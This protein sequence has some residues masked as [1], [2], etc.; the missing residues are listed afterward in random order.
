MIVMN[1]KIR[2]ILNF[3]TIKQTHFPRLSKT[4]EDG[5]RRNIKLSKSL[6]QKSNLKQTHP[7][8][9]AATDLL[10]A[11]KNKQLRADFEIQLQ[12]QR[13][14]NHNSWVKTMSFFSGPCGLK[15]SDK[16]NRLKNFKFQYYGY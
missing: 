3:T 12:L 14:K 15:L 9:A 11:D 13:T 7:S 2:F 10:L 5:Q 8:F 6:K 16:L 1:L 4:Y